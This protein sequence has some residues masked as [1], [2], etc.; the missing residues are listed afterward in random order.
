[1]PLDDGA[2]RLCVRRATDDDHPAVYVVR[3]QRADDEGPDA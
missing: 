2:A 1:M 3:Y